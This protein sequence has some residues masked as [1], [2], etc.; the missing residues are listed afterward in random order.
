M[1]EFTVY[2]PAHGLI[3]VDDQEFVGPCGVGPIS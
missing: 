1:R 3:A 2:E